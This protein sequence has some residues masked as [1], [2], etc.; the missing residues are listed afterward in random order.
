MELIDKIKQ[1]NSKRVLIQV[2]EGLKPASFK[3]LNDLKNNQIEPFLSIDPCYGACDLADEEA[4]Q[5]GCDLL[6]HIGHN[7]F[8]KDFKTKVPVLYDEWYIPLDIEKTKKIIENFEWPEKIVLLTTVQHIKD[9]EK[10]AGIFKSI[11][12]EIVYSSQVLGCWPDI[13]VEADCCVFIGSGEFHPL[14]LNGK[15][16]II[17][18]ESDCVKDITEKVNKKQRQRFARIENFKDCKKVGILVSSKKGQFAS[19]EEIEEIK[20]LLKSNGKDVYVLIGDY[21]TDE[22]L[23]GIKLDGFVNTACPRIIEDKFSKTVI[24]KRDLK[25]L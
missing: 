13:D 11:G 12:K 15:V 20:N 18:I 3:I 2:P 1:T 25:Y 16:Y 17:D 19:L 6:V 8:Y 23:M 9:L 4:Y 22:N 24:N 21:I 7:K 5:L 10:V 14:N